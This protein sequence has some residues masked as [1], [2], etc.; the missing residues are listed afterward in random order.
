MIRNK[1]M[2][3]C[4]T[5]E[6]TLKRLTM[7]LRR[8][9]PKGYV[10]ESGFRIYMAAMHSGNRTR[11]QY[12]LTGRASTHDNHTIIH[13]T[14]RP[15]ALTIVLLCII[16]YPLIAGLVHRINGTN[17]GVF[18]LVSMV[19]NIVAI[20]IVI[21]QEQQCI[22]RFVKYFEDQRSGSAISQNKPQ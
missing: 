9:H 11:F 3:L 2:E 1:R 7:Q 21:W 16:L 12:V 19:A 17:N 8:T 22:E 5:M 10:N 4:L 18:L 13:Y 6:E 20:L 14:L 15:S